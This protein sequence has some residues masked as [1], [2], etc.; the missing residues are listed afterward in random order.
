MRGR[1]TLTGHQ[2]KITA[3][4]VPVFTALITALAAYVQSCNAQKQV[5]Q[6]QKNIE[7]KDN[8]VQSV[9][10]KA[11]TA[12]VR[13]E[14]TDKELDASYQV[15]AD[16][17]SSMEKRLEYTLSRI[18]FLERVLI[19]SSFHPSVRNYRPPKIPKDAVKPAPLPPTPTSAA[20]E[21]RT[22]QTGPPP[23]A[24]KTDKN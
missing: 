9:E 12:K 4:L 20:K 5:E 3:Y 13:A 15:L 21:V 6:A 1:P 10:A 7:A 23:A 18:E 16:R 22:T 19:K 17:F 11:V 24:P 8:R 2:K 14:R